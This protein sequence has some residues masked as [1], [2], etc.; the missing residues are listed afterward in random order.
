MPARSFRGVAPRPPGTFTF[1]RD[2][3]APG[4]LP[5]DLLAIMDQVPRHAEDP[6]RGV[7]TDGT[8]RPGLFSLEGGP[9]ADIRA[10]ATA[11]AD[12]LA[13]LETEDRA[14]G[15]LPMDAREWRRWTNA[16]P[17]WRPHGVLLADLSHATRDAALA[18]IRASLSLEGYE[19]TRTV[20]LFNQILGQLI[21]DYPGTLQEWMYR[22]TIFGAPSTEEPWGWQLAGHHLDLHCVVVRGRI[23]LTPAFMG[24]EP[25]VADDGPWTGQ[26]LFDAEARQ[27]RDLMA[28]LVPDERERATLFPSMRTADLPPEFRHP[29]EGRM[30]A[31]T[32]ADNLVLPYQGIAVRDFGAEARDLLV[33]LVANYVRIGPA[34]QA[35]N[36]MAQ[37]TRHLDETHFAWV[38]DPVQRDTFYYRI[39]SPV[40]LIEFDHHPGVF[41]SND[42][43]AGFHVHTVVRTPNGN[44]YGKDLLRQHYSHHHHHHH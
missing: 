25:V 16:Y 37:V 11:A 6:Y 8:V 3:F 36:R 31:T 23:V 5:P 44:D 12:Y 14:A 15:Q 40:I 4:S 13:A 1:D 2:T 33:D 21:D 29:T 18:V 24:A 17:T 42:D 10:M 43:P 20:M 39:H 30:K 28:S 41:L 22:F 9:D 38:G 19:R 35:R 26:Q 34:E 32:G 27:A 7:T